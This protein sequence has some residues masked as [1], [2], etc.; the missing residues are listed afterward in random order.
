MVKKAIALGLL[1]SVTTVASAQVYKD[2]DV[3]T[4]FTSSRLSLED[5]DKAPESSRAITAANQEIDE[6]SDGEGV[7]APSR[8]S[9]FLSVAKEKIS[10]FFSWLASAFRF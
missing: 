4:R 6:D 3:E 7:K 5:L 2:Q 8:L 1:L 9:T 10:G